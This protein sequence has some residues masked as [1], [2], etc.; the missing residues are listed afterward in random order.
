MDGRFN[1]YKHHKKIHI[2]CVLWSGEAEEWNAAGMDDIIAASLR[3]RIYTCVESIINLKV[4]FFQWKKTKK[5]KIFNREWRS[6]GSRKNLECVSF[7]LSQSDSSRNLA[8]A[9]QKF[10]LLFIFL[11][12]FFREWNGGRFVFCRLT[13]SFIYRHISEFSDSLKYEALEFRKDHYFLLKYL[14]LFLFSFPIFSSTCCYKEFFFANSLERL[15][16][17]EQENEIGEEWNVK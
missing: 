10:L 11:A 1:V 14:F 5:Q 16:D 13:W 3:P 7:V 9:A 15:F 4:E 2:E 8:A 12:C 17:I 6:G